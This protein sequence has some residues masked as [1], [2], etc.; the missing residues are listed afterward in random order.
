MRTEVSHPLLRT[1]P[2]SFL[3]LAAA[4]HGIKLQNQRFCRGQKV[5][6]KVRAREGGWIGDEIRD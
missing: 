2:L 6:E 4:K 1:L 3:L 5:W